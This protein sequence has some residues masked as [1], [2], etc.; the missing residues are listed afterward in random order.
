M[1]KLTRGLCSSSQ[2][3]TG[4][5]SSNGFS[6]SCVLH[7]VSKIGSSRVLQQHANATAVAF[8]PETTSSRARSLTISSTLRQGCMGSRRAFSPDIVSTAGWNVRSEKCETKRPRATVVSGQLTL[9]YFNIRETSIDA[10]AGQL[11]VQEQP[12]E[13]C[14]V[15]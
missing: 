8:H 12:K 1:G 10:D 9:T 3:P 11:W 14:F 15:P 2:T 4:K 6:R 13:R 5:V 7:N